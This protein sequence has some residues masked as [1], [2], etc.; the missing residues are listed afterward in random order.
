MKSYKYI[1]L[2]ALAISVASCEKTLE[3]NPKYTINNV[4]AFESE[5]TANMVLMGCYAFLTDYN[6]YGQA[7]QET[8]VGPTGL[9]FGQNNNVNYVEFASLNVTETNGTIGQVWSGYYKVISECNYFISS[10]EK[11]SLSTEYKNQALGEAKFIRAL[12]Y[13][14]LANLF[15]GVPLRLDPTNSDNINMSRPSREDV[16]K[17][18]EEDWIFAAEHLSANKISGRASKYAAYAYL[19]KLYWTLGSLDNTP[20]SPYWAKAKETGDIVLTSGGFDLESNFANL[21]KVYSVNSPESIFQIN[22]SSSTNGFGNRGNWIFSA[23]NSSNPGISWARYRAS[24]PYYDHFRGTYPDDPR[25]EATFGTKIKLIKTNGNILY[26]YPYYYTT[27]NANTVI[28]DSVDYS[29]APDPTNPSVDV[30]SEVLKTNFINSGSRDFGW[31]FFIKQFD[32]SATA[33]NSKKNL[34]IYRYADFLLIMADVENEL[35]PNNPLALTYLNKV[36]NRAR[37]SK[38]N[39]IYPK[40]VSAGISQNQ[41]REMIFNERLFELAGEF[42]MFMDVRRRGV[43]FFKKVIDRH[44]NHHITKAQ[45][46]FNKSAGNNLS[47]MDYLILDG[48]NDVNDFLKKNLLLPIP[49]NEISNNEGISDTDQNYGY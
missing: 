33:Q 24:K 40:A 48:I 11:S 8:V 9:I 17:L 6:A 46:L 3:E 15:G 14:N 32:A 30:L 44:D 25:L 35:R 20:S 7:I 12:C 37:T 2:A 4:T 45:V 43:E 18:V 29:V 5:E 38:A 28:A 10:L 16:Y 26:T 1:F 47:F 36:L 13:F 34:M 31:P 21:F 39:A 23:S 27:A 19:T 41:L 22:F 49:R 42:D